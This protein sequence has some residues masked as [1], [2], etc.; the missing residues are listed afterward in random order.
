[1][2]PRNEIDC[3]S[4]L[5]TFTALYYFPF[6][7]NGLACFLNKR[8]VV[9]VSIHKI[10]RRRIFYMSVPRRDGVVGSGSAA[11]VVSTDNTCTLLEGDIESLTLT[12]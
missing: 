4:F 9:Y 3:N 10:S 6:S 7:A 8:D 11:G 5:C 2:Q 12:T 1:M